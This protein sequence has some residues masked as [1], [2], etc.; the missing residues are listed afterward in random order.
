MVKNNLERIGK[1]AD[2]EVKGTLGM[3]HPYMYR[4]K[5][6]F[7]VDKGPRIG[8]FKRGSHDLIPIDKCIIQNEMVDKIIRLIK[9]YMIK[10]KVEGYDRKDKT[11]IIKNILIRTTKDNKAMVV[12]ITKEDGLPHKGEL[13]KI[14]IN[15]AKVVSIYQNINNRDTSVVLGPKDIK[16][17]GEDR[18][19]DYIGE[20]KFLISPKSFFQVNSIQTEVLYNKVLEYLDLKGDETVVDL[21]CGIG[22][23]AIYISKHAKKVYG[24]E[25]VKEAII[26]FKENLKL[27]D[28][29]NVEFIQ[30][31][32]EDILPKLN[33]EGVKIDAIIV[34]PPRKGLDKTLIDSIIKANPERIV[35]VSCNPSTLAR[36]LGYLGEKGYRAKEVQPV[37][38][39][40]MTTHCE[41]VTQIVKE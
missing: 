29:N 28:V 27:N 25:I 9:E 34:D 6:E 10:Y 12:V 7:K 31:K 35:Y 22:T 37:D 16:L 38:V 30:G 11:G 19:M 17:Y 1:L 21:Y 23:I 8:Y 24:V 4:N 40:P 36:D 20:Y 18:I 26:D 33:T 2:V 5:A 13:I 14:L 41:V 39:F 32:S 3:D 15:N